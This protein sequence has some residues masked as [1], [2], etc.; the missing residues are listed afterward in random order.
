MNKIEILA[1][2]GNFE[3]AKVAINNGADAI[4]LGLNNFNARGNIEN[5]NAEELTSVVNHAHLFNVKVYLTLNILIQDHEFPEVFSLVE[6]ALN[7]NVDAFI[8][9]DIGL[10]YFLKQNFPNIELHASTQM[11]FSNLEGVKFAQKIGFKRVVLARETSLNEIKKIKE[12]CNIDLEY[13]IQGALCVSFSGNCYLSS[14]LTNNSG[15]RGKCKQLCRLPFSIQ[16]PSSSKQGYMISTKDFC[17]V[18]K[19]K[20]LIDAGITSLKI[21]GRARR[22][23]Y[24][25]QAVATYKQIIENNFS[26]TEQNINDLKKSF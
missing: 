8:V 14:L 26:F 21:E 6:K 9:Q 24:V 13:F 1:P 17:M 4:Y 5:F 20:E 15:N 12:N 22:P 16:T 19:L 7:A 2:A 3:S 25:G 10:A 18:E 23:A 11:G